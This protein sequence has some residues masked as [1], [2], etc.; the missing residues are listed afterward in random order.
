L[1]NNYY[2]LR[3]LTAQLV[4]PLTGTVISECFSQSKDELILRFETHGKPFFIKAALASSFACLAFP[5]NFQRAKKNS[6]D[7]FPGL[8]GFRVQAIKQ[9]SNERSFVLIL[10]G[11]KALLFKMHGNRSNVILFENGTPIELFKNNSTS[12]QELVLT[13]LDRSIDWS[14]EAFLQ[15]QDKPESLYFTFGKIVWT[16]LYGNGYRELA[17]TEKW[18]LIRKTVSILEHPSY[19]LSRVKNNIHLTLLPFTE[20]KLLPQD[21][22]EATNA[23]YFAFTHDFALEKE[24]SVIIGILK[25]KLSGS[26]SYYEKNFQKLAE[27]E[28]DTNFKIWADLIMANMHELKQGMEKIKLKD[29]YQENHYVDI[30][31]KKELSPQDN[32]ALFY[33]KAKNQHIEIDRMRQSLRTKEIEIAKLKNEIEQ[34]RLIDDLKVFRQKVNSSGIQKESEK[35]SISLP[36]HEFMHGGF[37]ILVGKNAQA[38]DE[39]TFRHGFKDDLWLHAKD[40]SGSHVLIKYQSGK[41]FPK[42]V[43]ER[44]AELAAYNSKRKTESLCPVIVTPR[45]FVR[46]RKGDPAGAVVVERENIIMVTPKLM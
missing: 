34:L 7:L 39:L 40:V 20:S 37:K 36:Y 29:F 17:L 27:I 22:I 15:H 16:Y 43:I 1:H 25:S 41:N 6:V 4:T 38:N 11:Q 30:K 5:E 46:K 18:T 2:F 26:E 32:A 3:Q 14:Y 21:P 45:K 24:K 42:D 9:F 8:I 35:Q 28:R 23:F 12:D 33:K 19:Y 31:L 44:A 13:N 10:D